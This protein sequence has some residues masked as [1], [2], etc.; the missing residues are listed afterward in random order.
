MNCEALE[1][2]ASCNLMVSTESEVSFRVVMKGGEGNT[3]FYLHTD[4]SLVV[5]CP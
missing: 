5:G 3:P 2:V 1:I 4:P